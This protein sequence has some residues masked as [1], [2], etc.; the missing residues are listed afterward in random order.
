[1]QTEIGLLEGA[2]LDAAVAKAEGLTPEVRASGCYVLNL[3]P[4][5]EFYN[6]SG[7]WEDGGLIVQ[8][9]RIA[10]VWAGDR[11]A[12]WHRAFIEV[13]GSVE[14]ASNIHQ[15]GPTPLIAAMRAYVASKQGEAA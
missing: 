9:D 14:S 5:S 10:T 8:R 7:D 6:P 3:R 4:E 1:M 11:W 2:E 15:Y 12:A 13:G